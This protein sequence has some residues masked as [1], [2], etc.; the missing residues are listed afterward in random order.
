MAGAAN[1]RQVELHTPYFSL[2][3]TSQPSLSALHNVLKYLL[4]ERGFSHVVWYVCI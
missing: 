2:F 1:F 3:G 4:I